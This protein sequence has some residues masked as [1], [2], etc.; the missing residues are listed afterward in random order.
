[1][2]DSQLMHDA[3]ECI[4]TL[5]NLGLMGPGIIKTTENIVKALGSDKFDP[6]T[7]NIISGCLTTITSLSDEQLE[8]LVLSLFPETVT[9][10]KKKKLFHFYY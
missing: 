7:K 9:E 3:V 4:T 1:M 2:G 8:S 6:A 5:R 10:I